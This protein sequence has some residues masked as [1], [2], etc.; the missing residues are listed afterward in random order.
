MRSWPHRVA[1]GGRC[2]KWNTSSFQTIESSGSSLAAPL[3]FHAR[4]C[5]RCPV[6]RTEDICQWARLAYMKTWAPVRAQCHHGRA[7]N[8]QSASRGSTSPDSPALHL[9][10]HPK[11]RHPWRCSAPRVPV[12]VHGTSRTQGPEQTRAPCDSDCQTCQPHRRR[13]HGIQDS[14]A[15]S[16][17]R[18]GRG[19]ALAPVKHGPASV[20]GVDLHRRGS[21]LPVST[22]SELLAGK[23]ACR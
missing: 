11:P 21:F 7:R 10:P 13:W 17:H 2:G 1:V 8:Y 18:R 19:F 9:A 3:G 22:T 14:A 5:C 20:C 16:F 4:Q 6:N 15:K 12:P 23:R